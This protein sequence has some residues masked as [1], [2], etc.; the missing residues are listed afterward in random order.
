MNKALAKETIL[1]V[2]DT[3]TDLQ[4]LTEILVEKGYS[5][6]CAK[7]GYEALTI[8]GNQKLDLILLDINMPDLNG[9]QVC[10]KLKADLKTREIPVIFISGVSDIF[11]KVQAFDFDGVDYISKPFEMQEVLARVQT[12]LALQELQKS[13]QDKNEQLAQTNEDL[14]KTLQELQI[15]QKELIQ[16]EKMAALGELVA[17]LAHEINTPLGAITSSIRNIADFWQDYLPSLP[18][19]FQEI[20]QEAKQHFFA[21]L[22]KSMQ[23]DTHLS[24]RE[25]RRIKK[26]LMAQLAVHE[27]EN[28]EAIANIL[29]SIGI[30]EDLEPFLGL[31]KDP[32]GENILKIADQFA[33][34]QTSTRTISIAS[35]RAAKVVFALRTYARYDLS[36]KK[37][38]ANIPE[39]IETVLILYSNLLK[40]GVQVIRNYAPDLPAILCYP[41]ELNQVWTNLVHNGIQAMAENGTLT[42]DV[43][44]KYNWIQVKITDSGKGIEP[45]IVPKIFNPFFTTK[46]VG[47]GNGLGLNIVQKIITKHQGKIEVQSVPGKT[48]FTVSLPKS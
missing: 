17:G 35:E 5:V 29:V 44:Q 37:V 2:D 45:E 13:L 12:H 36:E 34:V 47:E 42:I 16:S 14:A 26:N 46:P 43:S 4:L 24:T 22:E 28:S 33:K 38:E 30:K 6:S 18:D 21:L 48:T 41:D 27:I 40:R 39:G 19:F 11:D 10:S 20:S 31:I 15:T 8:A 3:L 23:K 25:T 32:K 1:V 9:Y 7:N